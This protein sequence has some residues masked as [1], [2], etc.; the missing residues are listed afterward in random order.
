[1]P[2]NRPIQHFQNGVLIGT[3]P[4]TI[5][6][7]QLRSEAAERRLV[8][9]RNQLRQIRIMAQ[10]AS[11]ATGAL[12][13][14]QLTTQFRQLAGALAVLAQTLMDLE[15]VMAVNQDDGSD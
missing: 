9:G 13:L 4:L 3:T 7:A 10:N 1:M 11:D 8:A 5:Q 14:V 15:L 2:E 6:D 12:T